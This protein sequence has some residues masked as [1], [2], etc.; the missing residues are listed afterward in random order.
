MNLSAANTIIDFSI[1]Y[2]LGR[3]QLV[4]VVSNFLSSKVDRY[5]IL[6]LIIS[7]STTLFLQFS[8]F[9][10]PFCHCF[11]TW[12]SNLFKVLQRNDDTKTF[13]HSILSRSF[14]K[15]DNNDLCFHS[16]DLLKRGT[17]KIVYVQNAYI[18]IPARDHYFLS[19]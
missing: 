7:S 9:L 8:F 12:N 17:P 19:V 4:V 10:I 2:C 13:I 14:E 15:Q 6:I 18:K 16:Y 11:I 3:Q 1:H 5:R